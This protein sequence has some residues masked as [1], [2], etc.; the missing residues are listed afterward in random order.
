MRHLDP[1][2]R[3]SIFVWTGCHATLLPRSVPA[4][5]PHA[6]RVLGF[7]DS[8]SARVTT[9][10]QRQATDPKRTKLPGLKRPKF[11]DPKR[12]KSPNPERIK[13]CPTSRSYFARCVSRSSHPIALSRHQSFTST[14][15]LASLLFAFSRRLLSP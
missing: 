13:G 3:N 1:Q 7:P 15:V 4:E 14:F 6:K 2:P 10:K 5:A 9:Q 8:C 11:P 12:P